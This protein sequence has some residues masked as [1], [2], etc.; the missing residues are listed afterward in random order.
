MKRAY[1][2][3]FLL[4]SLLLFTMLSSTLTAGEAK[5]A[6]KPLPNKLPVAIGETTPAGW[7]DDYNVAVKLA[8]DTNRP[9][10]VFFTGSD[11]CG[12]CKKLRK[13]VLDT[14]AFKAFAAK[15]LVMLYV[16]SPSRIK[17]PA[18]LQRQNQGL[19]MMLRH[20]GGVPNTKL[21]DFK[22]KKIGEIPGYSKRFQQEIIKFMEASG[23]KVVE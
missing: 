15:N 16:D 13:D 1:T 11:W 12:W 6:I 18:N 9:L 14:P 10:L 4:V 22:G 17:L 23:F 20:T 3:L 8:R 7:L 19:A 2:P 5:S 21:Y